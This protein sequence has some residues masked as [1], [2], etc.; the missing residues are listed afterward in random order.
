MGS[1]SGLV[2]PLYYL[3]D[4]CA[5]GKSLTHTYRTPKH[6]VDLYQTSIKEKG[7]KI[8]INFTDGNE[9]DLTFYNTDLFGGHSEKMNYVMND[10]NTA[11]K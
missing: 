6:L 8:E 1:I 3:C 11:T 10:E 9:L 5:Y 7:K 2:S 4:L